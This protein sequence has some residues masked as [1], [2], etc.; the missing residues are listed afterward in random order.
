MRPSR[1]LVLPVLLA[2]LALPA[3]AQ[4]IGSTIPKIEL[5]GFGNTQAQSFDDYYGRT[6]LLEFFAFW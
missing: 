4:G 3:A 6:V 2:L 1:S 5:E